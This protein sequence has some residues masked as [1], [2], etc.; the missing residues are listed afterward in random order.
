MPSASSSTRTIRIRL[1]FPDPQSPSTPAVSGSSLGSVNATTSASTRKSNPGDQRRFAI[2]PHEALVPSGQAIDVEP[3]R[4]PGDRGSHRDHL[5]AADDK[6][7][8]LVRD[9]PVT[10]PV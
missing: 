5:G 10:A 7:P 3:T 4:R 8:R 2:R 9:L 6:A 1:L